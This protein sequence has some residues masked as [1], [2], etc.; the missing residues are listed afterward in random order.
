MKKTWR[1]S[2]NRTIKTK[3]GATRTIRV[4]AAMLLKQN[5]MGYAK[6]TRKRK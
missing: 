5:G 2:H 6:G 1:N 3:S 4:R